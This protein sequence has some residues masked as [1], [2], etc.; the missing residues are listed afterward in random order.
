MK[1]KVKLFAGV[2]A[3]IFTVGSASAAL[4]GFNDRALWEAAVG[5][6]FSSE[7]FSTTA[8]AAYDSAPLDVGDFTVSITGQSFGPS[9]HY[10]GTNSV[11]ANNVNGTQQ[12]NV[13]TG[14]TGGTNLE[15]DVGIYA[16]G[17]DWAGVSDSRTT[18]FMIDGNQLD[19]PNLT[20]GFYGFVSDSAFT[21]NFLSLTFGAADGFG[22]DNL[23]YASAVREV[24][25]PS[26]LALLLLGFLG[27]S[28]SRV[29]KA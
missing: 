13:A 22:M 17:A 4:I 27:L 24:P 12:L 11:A 3:C 6:N 14:N 7:D 2:L 8:S 15:F 9:W 21:S 10:V 16:F 25:E 1:T 28:Y 23:V 26:T 5:G 18:S 29:K 20:G 19:I